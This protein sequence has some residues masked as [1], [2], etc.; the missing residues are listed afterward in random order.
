MPNSR[1]IETGAREGVYLGSQLPVDAVPGKAGQ[2]RA[3]PGAALGRV[4]FN[5]DLCPEMDTQRRSEDAQRTLRRRAEDAQRRSEAAQ[6][7]FRG[8]QWCQQQAPSAADA[9]AAR[10]PAA[11][12]LQLEVINFHDFFRKLRSARSHHDD[13][14]GNSRVINFHD[15]F[16]SSGAPDRTMMMAMATQESSFSMTFSK[17]QERQIAP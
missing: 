9:A 6:G 11:R 10:P 13:G 14:N 4:F 3:R 16:E 7:M 2:G 17:A 1:C 12:P 15:F 5:R 8:A